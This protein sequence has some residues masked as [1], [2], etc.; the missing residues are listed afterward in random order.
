M[1]H[2]VTIN[3]TKDP[4]SALLLSSSTSDHSSRQIWIRIQ[5]PEQIPDPVTKSM[6]K[7]LTNQFLSF[8]KLIETGFKKKEC[9]M[10]PALS[11]FFN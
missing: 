4:G 6:Q 2:C 10:I 11:L 7:K 5:P 8:P 9:L 3:V 1:Q